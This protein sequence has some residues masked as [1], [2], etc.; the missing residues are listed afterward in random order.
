MP[1]KLNSRCSPTEKGAIPDDAKGNRQL[2]DSEAGDVHPACFTATPKADD[3]QATTKWPTF[4]LGRP[5][6]RR[7]RQT[8]TRRQRSGRHVPPFS[9]R[10]RRQTTTRRQRSGRRFPRT[11]PAGSFEPN[12]TLLACLE[13]QLPQFSAQ[14]S[15]DR[16]G[17]PSVTPLEAR[18]CSR[19]LGDTTPKSHLVHSRRSR[20][21]DLSVLDLHSLS[22]VV[23]CA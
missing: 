2:G 20:G 1:C 18:E 16:L 22:M 12:Q 19:R 23:D 7:R 9:R 8:T 10:R 13:R 14:V 3:N 15:K 4:P 21:L 11:P 17:H 6:R 5:S